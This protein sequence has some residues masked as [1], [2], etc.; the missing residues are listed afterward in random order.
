MSA[1]S[2]NPFRLLSELI[3]FRITLFVMFSV[4][5]GFFLFAGKVDERL[6]WAAGGVFLLA[7]GAT[8]INQV[9]ERDLDGRMER[10]RRRPI[11][12]GR[13]TPRVA[14]MIAVVLCTGGIALLTQL[15]PTWPVI[16]GAFT[17]LWYNGVYTPLKRRTP[18]AV[19]PGALV[20]ALPPLIGWT[21][22]GGHPLDHDALHLAG[23]F[24]MW[25]IPHFWILLLM[26]GPEYRA[27]GIPSLHDRFAT[28][29]LARFTG[30]WLLAA[31]VIGLLT[32]ILLEPPSAALGVALVFSLG[33][34]V[35]ALRLMRRPG[36]RWHRPFHLLNLYVV[37]LTLLV[38][39]T[40]IA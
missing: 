23:F 10:T 37:A 11:P 19:I 29:V 4:S 1:Q 39:T 35:E 40:A 13:L 15:W 12:S 25:Q 24:Y 27:A 18:F 28:G 33:L 30:L 5:A 3:R 6:A 16:L 36:E 7:A 17:L 32:A 8:A 14:L 9:Q 34:G 20:G 38:C 31:A 2:G 22:A 26:L 21:A